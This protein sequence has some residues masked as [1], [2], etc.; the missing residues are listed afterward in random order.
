MVNR[1]AAL[2]SEVT[3]LEKRLSL[4]EQKRFIAGA[5]IRITEVNE[6][7]TLFEV[8]TQDG[9][10]ER[11]SERLT[12]AEELLENTDRFSDLCAGEGLILK[13][14]GLQRVIEM[15]ASYM[16]NTADGAEI[17]EETVDFPFRIRLD[18]T[19]PE[20]S[21]TKR[22]V[23]CAGGVHQ[24]PEALI[25]AGTSSPMRMQK[26][27]F[28]ADRDCCVYLRINLS[29]GASEIS[30]GTPS[31]VLEQDNSFP[32]PDS[33]QYIVPIAKIYFEETKVTIQQMHFGNIYIAGRVI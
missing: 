31:A 21:S 28:Y 4:L 26:E 20:D 16:D 3:R 2:E 10:L 15:N 22:F 9:E 33:G 8:T 12:H 19:Q 5:N 18:Y 27:V 24:M 32:S 6:T 11:L 14:D 29:P 25:Y 13:N 17:T 30:A 1:I 23:L 7:M